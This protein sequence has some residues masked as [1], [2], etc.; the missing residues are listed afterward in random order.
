MEAPQIIT[1]ISGANVSPRKPPT[2]APTGIPIDA[3]LVIKVTT[4]LSL[5]VSVWMKRQ[6]YSGLQLKLRQYRIKS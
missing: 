3:A 2:N 1:G 4:L 5:P 6:G